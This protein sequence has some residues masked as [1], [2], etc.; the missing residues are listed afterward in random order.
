MHIY[1]FFSLSLPYLHIEI[2]YFLRK[3]IHW[4]FLSTKKIRSR[5]S[6]HQAS[7]WWFFS[8]YC[9]WVYD[10]EANN[11][12]KTS[13]PPTFANT[14][15]HSHISN[16]EDKEKICA[17]FP[18]FYFI[19]FSHLGI[20]WLNC[21]ISFCFFLLL[22]IYVSGK[23]KLLNFMN[24]VIYWMNYFYNNKLWWV[25]KNDETHF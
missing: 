2:G 24:K 7:F 22:T 20:V 17:Q 14:L 10:E 9:E 12:K 25:R 16:F 5:K 1:E 18:W 19:Y 6:V 11:R 15:I 21:R 3:K 13:L 4:I 23:M 8:L